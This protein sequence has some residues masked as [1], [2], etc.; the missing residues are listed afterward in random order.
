MSHK[1]FKPAPTCPALNVLG[2]QTPVPW[3]K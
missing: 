1:G 3:Q 2:I